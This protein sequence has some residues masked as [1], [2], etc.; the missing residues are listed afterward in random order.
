MTV[1]QKVN[2]G[3]LLSKIKTDLP[4]EKKLKIIV[5]QIRTVMSCDHFQERRYNKIALIKHDKFY[6]YSDEVF[7]ENDIRNRIFDSNHDYIFYYNKYYLKDKRWTPN[8]EATSFKHL[9]YMRESFSLKENGTINDV[10]VEISFNNHYLNIYLNEIIWL[11]YNMALF[12]IG[13]INIDNV[14]EMI[15]DICNNKDVISVFETLNNNKFIDKYSRARPISNLSS[16]NKLSFIY[17][18]IKNIDKYKMISDYNLM[19]DSYDPELFTKLKLLCKKTPIENGEVD[20][21]IFSQQ[22]GPFKVDIKFKTGKYYQNFRWLKKDGYE[23]GT[24]DI[25]FTMNRGTTIFTY[26]L[27]EDS[28]KCKDVQTGII[29]YVLTTFSGHKAFMNQLNQKLLA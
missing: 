2:K 3:T 24:L 6:R 12:A 4:I 16:V 9:Y 19:M 21:F 11:Q 7:K 5:N 25:Y 28:S 29:S 27:N 14:I 18:I 26:G 1:Y 15:F 8:I 10:N 22:V 17:K 13:I 23:D 20:K